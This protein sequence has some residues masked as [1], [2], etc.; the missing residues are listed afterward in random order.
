VILTDGL[1][2]CYR[3][4]RKLPIS[5]APPKPVIHSNPVQLSS[6]VVADTAFVVCEP[7][8][9]DFSAAC[10]MD[11]HTEWQ[12]QA[13]EFC[14]FQAYPPFQSS[15]Q[16][17]TSFIRPMKPHIIQSIVTAALSIVIF[18]IDSQRLSTV[19]TASVAVNMDE[20]QTQF[21]HIPFGSI[22][23]QPLPTTSKSAAILSIYRTAFRE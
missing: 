14:I 17:F 21:V 22:I 5:I 6:A 10:I 9:S 3:L 18:L 19:K 23:W 15:G 4:V 16:L 8:F 20:I 7:A 13:E 12:S 2:R 11:I 1:L